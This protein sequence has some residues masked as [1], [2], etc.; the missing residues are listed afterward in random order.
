MRRA[1][2]RASIGCMPRSLRTAAGAG[3]GMPA[4]VVVIVDDDDGLRIALERV[5]RASGFDVRAFPSAED[6]LQAQGAESCACVVVDLQLP[7]MS[8]LELTDHL[9][10]R[11]L[12]A[13]VV[14]ISAHD[15]VH[16]RRAVA[17]RGIEHFL[18]KPFLGSTLAAQ[19]RS[20]VG[21][22]HSGAAA[23]GP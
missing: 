17:L 7:R 10:Q 20:L 18:A 12:T 5:L 15:E 23:Q 6:A 11:G 13:P 3:A 4:P 2:A 16:V 1:A 14:V 21:G 9:R 22:R 8:G 19:V